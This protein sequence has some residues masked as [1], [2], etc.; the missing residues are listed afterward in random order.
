VVRRFHA[1]KPKNPIRATQEH[2]SHLQTSRSQCGNVVVDGASGL[3]PEYGPSADQLNGTVDLCQDCQAR[4]IDWLKSSRQHGQMDVGAIGGTGDR[5]AAAIERPDAVAVQASA[6]LAAPAK[7][8]KMSNV[9]FVHCEHS[10]QSDAFERAEDRGAL[11]CRLVIGNG[12]R[13][14]NELTLRHEARE[15]RIILKKCETFR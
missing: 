3:K 12:R 2:H 13:K 6:Y 15:R 8:S 5:W 14:K 7:I 9:P 11:R 4:L 1:A 10:P